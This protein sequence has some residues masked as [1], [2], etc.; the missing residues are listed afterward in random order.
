M[1]YRLN[2]ANEH[3][4]IYNNNNKN[5]KLYYLLYVL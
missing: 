5:I 2:E 4:P 1:R 3:E